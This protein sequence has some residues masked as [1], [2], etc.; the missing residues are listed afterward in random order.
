MR[1]RTR[2]VWLAVS[3][4]LSACGSQVIMLQTP[5]T[6]SGARFRCDAERGCEPAS[7]DPPLRES[8]PDAA[9][10]ELPDIC[11]GRFNQLVIL[12]PDS[13]TPTIEVTCAEVTDAGPA[14]GLVN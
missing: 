12:E 7:V 4:G 2:L 10:I 3:L 6:T 14:T 1:I 11:R 13:S 9:Y 8:M 5:N